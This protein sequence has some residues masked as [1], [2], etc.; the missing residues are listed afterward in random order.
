MKKFL[1]YGVNGVINTVASYALYVLLLQVMDYRI[2]VVI[3]Y[4]AAV[5]LSYALNGA[6][7]FGMYG[8]FWRFAFVSLFLMSLNLLITWSLVEALEWR[9]EFAQLPAIAAVFVIGFFVNQRFV[10]SARVTGNGGS[11]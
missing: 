8:R 2:S 9:K 1:L 7:V 5:G 10:F 4:C 6:I 3:S 11:R